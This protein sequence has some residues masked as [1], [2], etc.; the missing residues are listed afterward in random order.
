MGFVDVAVRVL[1]EVHPAVAK[2]E[3]TGKVV[4]IWVDAKSIGPLSSSDFTNSELGFELI[5]LEVGL[6][7]LGTAPS[8]WTSRPFKRTEHREPNKP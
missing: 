8:T 1:F 2:L 7:L 4:K 6:E 5:D 3:W